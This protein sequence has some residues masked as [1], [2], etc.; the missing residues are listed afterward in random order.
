VQEAALIQGLEGQLT[1]CL[2]LL[3]NNVMIA[4]DRSGMAYMHGKGYMRSFLLA[5]VYMFKQP[6]YLGGDD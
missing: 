4:F 1:A 6:P 5:T 2:A 3:S